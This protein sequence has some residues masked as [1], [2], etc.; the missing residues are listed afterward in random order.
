[1]A[2]ETYQGYPMNWP[3]ELNNK[4]KKTESLSKHTTFRS[5]GEAAFFAFPG[6][7]GQ[8][9]L[10]VCTA[11][12]NK[13]PIRI[14]GAGS[15]ILAADRL[16]RSMVIKLSAPEFTGIAFRG[17][18]VYVGAAAALP[19]V[20]KICCD[21]GLGGLEFLSGIPATVG[22]ALVMN[23][24]AWDRNISNLVERVKVM[25]YNGKIRHLSRR[26]INF[27]YRGSGLSRYIVLECILLLNRKSRKSIKDKIRGY[28]L[29][30]RKTQDVFYPSA[31]CIFK[32]PK[33]YP[34]GMLI[35]ACGLKGLAFGGAAVSQAHANFIINKNKASSSDIIKL[36]GFI[37]REVKKKTGIQLEPEIKIWD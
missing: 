3:K 8:L 30:R 25:D 10:L 13:L 27:S 20:I 31:G 2:Q 21:K 34:A 35:E 24:G 16:K 33:D 9:K 18:R 15:N 14:I 11:K 29:R 28:L 36:M 6:S 4:I 5:G 17:N 19:R 1:L 7:A 26:A 32:N 37:R 23:A 22:G 12:K